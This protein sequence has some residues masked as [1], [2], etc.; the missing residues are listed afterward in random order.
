MVYINM[1]SNVTGYE[2]WRM[3]FESMEEPRRAHGHTGV[4]QVYRD[5]DNPNAVT[6]ILERDNAENARKFLASPALR[7]A[8]HKAGVIGAPV[9]LAVMAPA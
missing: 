1:R 8:M 4:K 5:S 7:E 9:V 6:L 2:H 3:A